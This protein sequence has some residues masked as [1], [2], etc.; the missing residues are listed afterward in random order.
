MTT[1]LFDLGNT[2]LKFAQLRDD[3]SLGEVR[4]IAHDDAGGWLQALPRGEAA[5]IASVAAEGRRVALLDALS[6]RFGRQHLAATQPRCGGLRIAYPIPRHLGVDRFLALLAALDAGDV[7]VVGIGT[8]IGCDTIP[9]GGG[10]AL[11]APSGRRAQL[12]SYT[13]APQAGDVAL[14][15]DGGATDRADDD[16]WISLA[17]SG[18]S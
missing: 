1:W 10:I 18:R 13:T 8:A 17:V 12:S 15:Y 4:A 11:V 7:L 3:G 9:G 16:S 2:R 5:C 14:I 6:T